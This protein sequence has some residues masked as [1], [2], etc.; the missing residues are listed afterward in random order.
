MLSFKGFKAKDLC[1]SHLSPGRRTFLRV[2]GCGMLGL[3]LPSLM[4]LQAKGADSELKN[5]TA[6]PTGGPGW[7]KAKSRGI[8]F[9]AD[10]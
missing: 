4:A 8:L 9:A 3:S 6:L 7:G 5:G 1:D 10:Q 2:G